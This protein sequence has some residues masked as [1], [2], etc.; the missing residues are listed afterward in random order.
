MYMWTNRFPAE[1]FEWYEDLIQ[2]P[3]KIKS[4]VMGEWIWIFSKFIE[5]K[6]KIKPQCFWEAC[7]YCFIKDYCHW[8]L[9]NKPFTIVLS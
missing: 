3:R 2:D 8:F 6:W 1:A 4:E 9:N 5:S 7:D